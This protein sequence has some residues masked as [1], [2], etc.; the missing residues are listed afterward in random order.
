MTI[1]DLLA[2]AALD[3]PNYQPK[4]AKELALQKRMQQTQRLTLGQQLKTLKDLR[5]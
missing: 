5:K 4:T 3:A 2:P 1:K